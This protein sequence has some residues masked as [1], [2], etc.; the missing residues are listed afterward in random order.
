MV[1][2][3]SR[4]VQ[5]REREHIPIQGWLLGEET[6]SETENNGGE[7]GEEGYDGSAAAAAAAA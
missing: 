4:V 6:R 5:E 2:R 3:A 7:A 1:G